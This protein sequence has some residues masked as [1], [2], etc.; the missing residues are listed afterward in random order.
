MDIIKKGV[1]RWKEAQ[2]QGENKVILQIAFICDIYCDI[3]HSIKNLT[4][5]N[6]TYGMLNCQVHLILWIVSQP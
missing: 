6:G 3:L 1:K 5:N 2:S 4:F